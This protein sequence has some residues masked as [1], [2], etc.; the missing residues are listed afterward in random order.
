MAFF[1]LKYL[2]ILGPWNVSFQVFCCSTIVKCSFGIELETR[3]QMNHSFPRWI[4]PPPDCG[5]EDSWYWLYCLSALLRQGYI[6]T[7]SQSARFEVAS[8]WMQLVYQGLLRFAGFRNKQYARDNVKSARKDWHPFIYFGKTLCT[9][10][11]YKPLPG[12][13]L[14]IWSMS[15]FR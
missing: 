15:Y 2:I 7:F 13:R 1:P 9:Q 12:L 5:G 11:T 3:G 4:D 8:A 14:V 10:H 6:G